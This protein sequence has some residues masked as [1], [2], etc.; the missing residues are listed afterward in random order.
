MKIQRLLSIVNILSSRR[1][2][3]AASQLAEIQGVSVRTIY[4]DIIDLKA[5]DIPILG[6]PGI[7]YQLGQ[8]YFLPTFHFDHD[9]IDSM[10]IGLQLIDAIVQNDALSE[11]AKRVLAKIALAMEKRSQYHVLNAPFK[12]SSHKMDAFKSN[13]YFNLI[14]L[15]IRESRY[16][17]IEYT[18]LKNTHSTR[19]VR[20]LGLTFFDEAWLLTAWC[21]VK[22]DFRNFRLDLIQ[23]CEQMEEVFFNDSNKTFNAYLKTL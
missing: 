19:V 9:E 17:Y 20:P 12:S 1:T 4:R 21:E 23:K 14:R 10:L 22:L 8:G 6:E 7:G 5:A 11:A 3:I 13:Q 16:L 2:P 18:D 15:T